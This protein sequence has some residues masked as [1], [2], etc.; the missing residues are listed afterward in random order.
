LSK[1]QKVVV[2]GAG[3]IG[4]ACAHYLNEA[5]FEVVIFDRGKAGGACSRANCGYICPEPYPTPY[6]TR[7]DWYCLKVNF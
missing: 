4:I 3:I 7:G 2:A 6:R 1:N 5:G